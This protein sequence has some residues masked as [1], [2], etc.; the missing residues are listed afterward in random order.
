MM[1]TITTFVA[2][3][4]LLMAGATALAADGGKTA[5]DFTLKSRSGKNVKLNE[6]RGQVVMI[7][8]WASWCG[9]CRKEMP[10]LDGLQ[11]KYADYG[12]KLL[13]VNV[14]QDHASAMKLLSHVPVDFTILFDP[15]SKVSKLYNV[16]AMPSTVI[17]GRDGHIR[18]RFRGYHSGYEDKYEATIKK[19]VLE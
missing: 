1:K 11:K 17:I 2:A 7:N 5:P 13:G 19:L 9:P 10:L 4:L 3:M 16:D 8:F 14:D 15:T 6:L 18:Q 12:F